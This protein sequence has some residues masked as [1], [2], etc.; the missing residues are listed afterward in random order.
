MLFCVRAYV[1]HRLSG[2]LHSL[3]IR[4]SGLPNA[5][6]SLLKQSSTQQIHR[7]MW[8]QAAKCAENIALLR[9]AF[10]KFV[11]RP[12]MP[13]FFGNNDV[14]IV[15]ISG[16]CITY[17]LSV[18]N[19]IVRSFVFG[20]LEENRVDLDGCGI[21][22]IVSAVGPLELNK[23]AQLYQTDAGGFDFF[24]AARLYDLLSRFTR[25]SNQAT[26][27]AHFRSALNALSEG[28]LRHCQTNAARSV[29]KKQTVVQRMEVICCGQLMSWA[30]TADGQE[31]H[32]ALMLAMAKDKSFLGSLAPG[33]RAESF[34]AVAWRAAMSHA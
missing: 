13:V 15:S 32:E 29:S 27:N 18:E 5:N 2:I 33:E 17:P 6:E 3:A 34:Y 28:Q 21:G 4:R 10:S 30:E 14:S 8:V 19:E 20:V 23:L 22:Q 1:V 7:N 11:A 31:E 9:W 16:S 24:A 12:P 25:G 26:K